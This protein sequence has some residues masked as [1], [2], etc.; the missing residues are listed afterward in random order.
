VT[1]SFAKGGVMPRL[2]RYIQIRQNEQPVL[3]IETVVNLQN[4]R[5]AVEENSAKIA[6][7]LKKSG[8]CLT[9]VPFVAYHNGDLN[10]LEVEICFPVNRHVSGGGEVNFSVIP[11]GDVVFCMLSG[12]HLERK[13]I[14]D[15]MMEWIKEQGYEY[16]GLTCEYFYTQCGNDN[17]KVLAKIARKIKVVKAAANGK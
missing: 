5:R 14:Y 2:S 8:G 6:E 7:F 3:V 12:D 9:D 15:E 13:A 1:Y 4:L 17:D 10:N 11:E 16:D